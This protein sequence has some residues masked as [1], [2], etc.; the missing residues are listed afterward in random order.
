MVK[1]KISY[2]AW[3][4]LFI[5]SFGALIITQFNISKALYFVA[6]G[7]N[8]LFFVFAVKYKGFK[9]IKKGLTAFNIILALYAVV[10]ILGA[11]INSVAFSYFLLG[12]RNNF[13]YFLF[14]YSCV[15]VLEKH[16]I[17]MFFKFLPKLYWLNLILSVFQK[18]VMNLTNDYIGGI[19]GIEQGCN[20][21]ST[22]FLNICLAIFTSHY[23]NKQ[24]SLFRLTLYTFV[25]FIITV[26][27]ELKGNYIF[28]VLIIAFELII[29]RKSRRTVMLGVGSLIAFGLGIY[30]LS[31][32]FPKSIEVLFDL[33]AATHY[34][35]AT[36]LRRVTFTR[37]A[38]FDVA[39]DYFFGDRWILSLFG[40]GL[41]ACE[42]S[43]FL[44][45]PFY[46]AYGDMNY[47]QYSAAM[48]LLQNGYV[49]LILFFT[50]FVVIGVYSF[51]Y[52]DKRKS[53]F[54]NSLY[55]AIPAI[56]LFAIFNN[57]Y[58][59]LLF[60]MGYWIWFVLAIPFIIRKSE[61]Q[62]E[63]LKKKE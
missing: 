1:F 30:L 28:F 48:I 27:A 3:I 35:N 44:V 56:A 47:R 7:V 45:T 50:L 36:Y 15:M 38:I 37:N 57:F 4:I 62:K 63:L 32:F 60:D 61:D 17:Q 20:G 41:G 9:E 21:S 23:I 11:I 58:A 51:R 13:R 25:Y 31:V 34:M 52:Y 49:G 12:I 24:L 46:A 26:F 19:F 2:F 22:I 53:D 29:G 10:C 8:V 55:M 39:N 59:T 43:S 42:M 5:V 14:F 18:Y 40:F 6:D 16:H 54:N 33:D